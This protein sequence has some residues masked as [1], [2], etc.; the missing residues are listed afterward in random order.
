M[1][2]PTPLPTQKVLGCTLGGAFAVVGLY[3]LATLANFTPPPS[4]SDAI[5]LL[6][7]AAAGYL[8]PHDQADFPKG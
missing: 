2:T 5:T 7:S 6:C 3:L 4:V 1:N 8:M